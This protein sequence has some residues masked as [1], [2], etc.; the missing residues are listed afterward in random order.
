MLEILAPFLTAKMG[1][2]LASSLLTGML[3]GLERELQGELHP[4]AAV[5][6]QQDAPRERGVEE[7]REAEADEPSKVGAARDGRAGLKDRW[8]NGKPDAESHGVPL[9]L[10]GGV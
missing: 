6:R 2:P 4:R 3:I 10:S 7:T 5:A 9:S 1:L 8:W